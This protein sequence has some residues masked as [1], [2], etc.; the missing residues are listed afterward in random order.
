MSTSQSTSPDP[1]SLI[2]DCRLAFPALFV[3]KPVSRDKPTELRYQAV[4]LLP[5]DFDL[6]PLFAAM[7]A[8]MLKK[9]GKAITLPSKNN[10]LHDGGEKPEYAGFEPGMKFISVKSKDRPT[11]VNR[12]AVPVVDPDTIYPGVYV[13]AYVEAYGWEHPVGGKGI[14]FALSA[15]Q[16]VRDGER[17]DGRRA[18]TDVFSPLAPLDGAADDGAVVPAD[19]FNMFS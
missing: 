10:P 11:V 7:A 8:A 12:A 1:R 17:L 14:S 18:A 2:I 3:P 4:L 13:K 5:A 9:W 6:K 15:V 19:D 16:I